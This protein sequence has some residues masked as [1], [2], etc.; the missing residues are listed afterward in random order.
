MNPNST[1]NP[2]FAIKIPLKEIE[3]KLIEVS[4]YEKPEDIPHISTTT[5]SSDEN[6]SKTSDIDKENIAPVED[7]ENIPSPAVLTVEHPSC[8]QKVIVTPEQ[9]TLDITE[10]TQLPEDLQRGVDLINCLVLSKKIDNTSK[11]KLIRKIIRRLL[12]TKGIEELQGLLKENSSNRE[13]FSSS[14]SSTAV[15]RRAENPQKEISGV[16]KLSISNEPTTSTKK[17]ADEDK[18]LSK[19]KTYETTQDW[20]EPLTQSEIEREKQKKEKEKIYTNLSI[21]END[22]LNKHEK[23]IETFSENMVKKFLEMEKRTHFNWIDREIEHLTNLKKILIADE[24]D[25]QLPSVENMDASK[26]SSENYFKNKARKDNIYENFKTRNNASSVSDSKLSV[27]PNSTASGR[28]KLQILFF[29]ES[30]IV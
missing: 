15:S 25:N 4:C 6:T 5:D 18:P 17:N 8:P 30:L 13:S 16:T 2:Q 12:R 24:A 10:D 14:S 7:K 3:S 26:L 28:S 21:T 19:G 9:Q 27:G 22:S 11:K 20:L 29:L 1:E 23:D